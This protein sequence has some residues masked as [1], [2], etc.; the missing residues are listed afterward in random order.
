FA[1]VCAAT[2][3]RLRRHRP[4]ANAHVGGEPATPFR[5][6]AL[7]RRKNYCRRTDVE[8]VFNVLGTM[9]SCPTDFYA[10]YSV[11]RGIRVASRSASANRA[12]VPPVWMKTTS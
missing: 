10:A 12:G 7:G 8:H 6:A 2:A 3:G 5:R 4:T 1:E 9:E 11:R